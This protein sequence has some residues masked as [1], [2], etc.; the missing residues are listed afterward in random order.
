MA[1][2]FV[3]HMLYIAGAMNNE[4]SSSLWNAQDGF[5]YDHFRRPDGSRI[6]IPVRTMVGLTP[7]FAVASAATGIHIRFPEFRKRAG[8]FT[9]HRPDLA[10]KV[11]I[12]AQSGG[13]ERAL[14]ALVLPAQ[15]RRLLAFM[16][17]ESE[18]LS[19]YGL[20]A[21]S[22]VYGENPFVLDA[23]GYHFVLDYA[24][25]ESTDNLFGGNSNWRGPIWLPLN[26]L[27]IESLQLFHRYFGDEFKVECPT[28]S[29]IEMD[30]GEVAGELARRLTRIFVRE[31]DA[32]A[33]E[34]PGRR[35]VFGD[36]TLMQTDPHWRDYILFH[37]Y[38]HGDNGSGRGASHQTG[39]TGLI[40]KIL[41]QLGEKS[42]GP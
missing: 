37:E 36:Y 6:P 22:K 9:Q 20:R 2:K 5:F 32:Q 31:A 33:P 41:Q 39:W 8:W 4:T 7:I 35:A 30:L 10:D 12:L 40:A 24:P 23:R 29:G 34:G 21:V 26:Y 16:L 13:G 17:D 42:T 14:L 18:F 19:P 1:I 38:F 3:E 27:V 11:T 28:G 15:L 25:G